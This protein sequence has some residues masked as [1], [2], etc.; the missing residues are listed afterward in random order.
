MPRPGDFR[1]AA[2]GYLS[3]GTHLGDKI[4]VVGS[5]TPAWLESPAPDGLLVDP[6]VVHGG[7]GWDADE[8]V[9]LVRQE[10]E[11]AD[12]QGFR[13]LRVLAE[14]D[15][16]W[17]ADI[18][19]EQVADQ[20]LRLNALTGGTAAMVVCAYASP[21]LAPKVL[22][23]AASVHPHFAGHPAQQPSFHIFSEAADCWRVSGVV[24]AD[25][26]GAFRAAVTG[27]LRTLATLRLRC[28]GLQLMDAVGMQTLADAAA[29]MP[30]RRIVLERAN[31]TVR[32]CWELLGY[33]D[34]AVPAELVP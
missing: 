2:L 19:A 13:A 15:R 16:I 17:P 21:G 12:R 10:A 18:T 7:V 31:P 1:N 32:R 9:S 24:D 27:L 14:M 23:Q 20:E 33:D 8:L 5:S 3:D 6:V 34:P 22:E 26:A 4:M 25:G 29:A 30:G 28:D 11:R